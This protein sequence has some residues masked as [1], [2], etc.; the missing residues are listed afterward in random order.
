MQSRVN[1][2]RESQCHSGGLATKPKAVT[3]GNQ[4]LMRTSEELHRVRAFANKDT[5]TSYFLKSLPDLAKKKESYHHIPCASEPMGVMAAA[6]MC[7]WQLSRL[8]PTSSHRR[9]VV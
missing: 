9:A 7:P 8:D 3:H 2:H 4:H 1:N 6:R 5:Q